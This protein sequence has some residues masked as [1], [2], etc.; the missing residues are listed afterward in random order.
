MWD[1]GHSTRV[2]R[3]IKKETI[4]SGEDAITRLVCKPLHIP[5]VITL[6]TLTH[7]CVGFLYQSLDYISYVVEM[8]KMINI[9]SR[10]DLNP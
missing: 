3:V 5:D 1:P 8:I 4:A 6:S 10:W 9:A 7:V 2:V